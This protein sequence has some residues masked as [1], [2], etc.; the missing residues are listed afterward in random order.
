MSELD[1]R[2]LEAA[3]AAS[4][5]PCVYIGVADGRE[6]EILREEIQRRDA[7][8]TALRQAGGEDIV[9]DQ[10]GDHRWQIEE[11]ITA[12]LAACPTPDAE[13]ME[14]VSEAEARTLIRYLLGERIE[15]FVTPVEDERRADLERIHNERIE[16][17]VALLTAAP[18]ER[19]ETEGAKP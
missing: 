14:R 10:V 3:I 16:H 4:W 18:V 6:H 15:L 8:W 17:I 12:Y 13:A 9:I 2:A 7:E 5:I 11:A 1:E 19:D